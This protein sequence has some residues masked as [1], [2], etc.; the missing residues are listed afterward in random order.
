MHA[1]YETFLNDLVFI[2]L[3]FPADTNNKIQIA[4]ADENF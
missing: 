3:W 4:L 2:E 1:Q